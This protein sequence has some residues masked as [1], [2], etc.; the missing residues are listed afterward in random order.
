MSATSN[1]QVKAR[2]SDGSEVHLIHNRSD[3]PLLDAKSLELLQSF[4]PDVVDFVI[5]ETEKEA[6][7][8]RGEMKRVN[9]FSF[10]AH[11][12]GLIFSTVIALSGLFAAY[13]VHVK[14][15]SSALAATIIIVCGGSL[16][17]AF[18]RKS[19]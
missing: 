14:G 2:D 9:T 8:R 6:S 16:A 15:G 5:G 17:I 11:V 13:S 4:R 7:F 19:S 12:L 3:S 18:L 10:I 1:T